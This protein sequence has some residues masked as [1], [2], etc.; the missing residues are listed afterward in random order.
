MNIQEFFDVS[1]Y[2]FPKVTRDIRY[3]MNWPEIENVAWPLD[4][5]T[6]ITI[7]L[8]EKD[9]VRT[10]EAYEKAPLKH[11]EDRDLYCLFRCYQYS[12]WRLPWDRAELVQEWQ[13]FNDPEDHAALEQIQNDCDEDDIVNDLLCMF[14]QKANAQAYFIINGLSL[15]ECVL[16]QNRHDAMMYQLLLYLAYPEQ[17][18]RG[19]KISYC[20]SCG[21][22]F[23]GER[24]NARFC[25]KCNTSTER[26]K[27]SRA[28]KD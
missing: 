10:L 21:E 25:A 28:K 5:N 3:L 12:V 23:V 20:K 7:L 27:R 17:A 4:T 2:D 1:Y 11:S 24:S 15:E 16:C 19:R 9:L 13:A 26:S 22:P 14:T 18:R 6:D 8:G